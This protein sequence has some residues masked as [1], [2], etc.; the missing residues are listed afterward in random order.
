ML[1]NILLAARVVGVAVIL[2][3]AAGVGQVPRLSATDAAGCSGDLGS[4]C[5]DPD[6]LLT[7]DSYCEAPKQGCQTCCVKAGKTCSGFSG[8]EEAQGKCPD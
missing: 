6:W 1:R 7:H 4:Y 5:A 8:Y 3:I 2:A